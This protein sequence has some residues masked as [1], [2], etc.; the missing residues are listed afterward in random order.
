MSEA[1]RKELQTHLELLEMDENIREIGKIL[2]GALKKGERHF[3]GSSSNL[4]MFTSTSNAVPSSLC[5]KKIRFDSPISY[6]YFH[7]SFRRTLGHQILKDTVKT[8]R[9]KGIE[10]ACVYH[11]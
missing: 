3:R 9:M 6:A 2:F 11:V 1:G 7:L 10:I 8:Q 4:Y 5:M